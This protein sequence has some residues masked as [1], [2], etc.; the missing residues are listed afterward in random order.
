ML[1]FPV[2]NNDEFMKRWINPAI[3]LNYGGWLNYTQVKNAICKLPV[4][5]FLH[6]I[7]SHL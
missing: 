7:D 6:S 2:S 1:G 3:D 4:R 5:S